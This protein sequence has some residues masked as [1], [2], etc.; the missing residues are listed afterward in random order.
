V[1]LA[2]VFVLLYLCTQMTVFMLAE[3]AHVDY[4]RKEVIL[5]RVCSW[6]LPDFH[7]EHDDHVTPAN[8]LRVVAPYLRPDDRRAL[9]RMVQEGESPRI[10]FRPYNFRC[11]AFSQLVDVVDG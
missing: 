6:F 10:R 11:R 2:L 7:T 4:N 1:I 5:P 3:T 9:T 8:C